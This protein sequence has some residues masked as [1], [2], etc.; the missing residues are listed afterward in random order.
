[1]VGSERSNSGEAY[2]D[3][4]TG[5]AFLV[6]INTPKEKAGVFKF[7]VMSEATP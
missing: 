4:E 7:P 5:R 6:F 3:Y 1:M 2:V